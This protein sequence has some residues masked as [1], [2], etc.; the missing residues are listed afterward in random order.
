MPAYKGWSEDYAKII[1]Y[2][3]DMIIFDLANNDGYF[4]FVTPV[5]E[6]VRKQHCTEICDTITRMCTQIEIKQKKI[7]KKIVWR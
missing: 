7:E 5:S 6:N 2:L 3:S 1:N 4:K